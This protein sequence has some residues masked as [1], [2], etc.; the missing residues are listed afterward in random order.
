MGEGI[1]CKLCGKRRAKRRCPAVN[2]D[3]CAICCG[4]QR[5]VTLSCPLECG[6]LCEAHKHEKTIAVSAREISN[7]QVEISE[8][9]VRSHEE[10]LLFCVY[11]LVQAALRTS[12][13]VDTDVLDSIRALIQTHRTAESGLIY[14]T[15]PANMVAASLQQKFSDSLKLYGDEQH[16][17]NEFSARPDADVFKMLV[18]LHRI[19][20]QNQNGRPK[21]R[22]FIDMLRGMT[23]ETRVDERA[24]SIIL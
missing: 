19:G 4:E 1:I 9:F 17:Q 3:I 23:P 7:P 21:G 13:A 14:E 24:P 10:L 8:D 2:G 16:K 11:S 12:N 5:E 15:K 18:F 6:F 20:Q 22:M